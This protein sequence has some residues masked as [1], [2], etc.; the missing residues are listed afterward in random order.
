MIKAIRHVGIVVK[1]IEKN[2]QF[3]RDIMGLRVREDFWEKGKFI[4]ELQ[5]LDNVKLHMIKL[6]APDGSMIELLKDEGN[7]CISNNNNKLCDAGIRHIAFTVDDCKKVW[8]ILH[9]NNCETLSEP[10]LNPEGTAK[11]FFAR[12]PEGNLLEIVQIMKG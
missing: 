2:L 7:P 4:N 9:E 8:N 11:V 12:D 3:W 10:I 6:V 1:D 5:N